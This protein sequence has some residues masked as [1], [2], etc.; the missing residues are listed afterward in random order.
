MTQGQDLKDHIQIHIQRHTYTYTDTH[1]DTHAD[2]HGMQI[3]TDTTN[4]RQIQ[5]TNNKQKKTRERH[6]T[7]YIIL[8]AYYI[9][10]AYYRRILHIHYS[11]ITYYILRIPYTCDT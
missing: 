6:I 9:Y 1:T 2:T 4:H 8:F 5:T 10:I 7:D 11:Y 3:H